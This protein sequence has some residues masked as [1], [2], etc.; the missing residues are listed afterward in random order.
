MR[1]RASTSCTCS[2]SAPSTTPSSTRGPR[3]SCR[4]SAADSRAEPRQRAAQ[5]PR[6]L[7]LRDARPAGDLG[8][9]EVLDEAQVQQ[10]AIAIVEQV[11]QAAEGDDVLR[12]R[13]LLVV[14]AERL[15]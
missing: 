11:A 1:T 12:A 6:D 2:R 13:E 4:G 9:R 3:R 5:Q 8:L 14:A 7:H 15:G 10:L